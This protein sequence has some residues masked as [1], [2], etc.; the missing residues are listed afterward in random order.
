MVMQHVGRFR[1]ERGGGQMN[2]ENRVIA[3]LTQGELTQGELTQGE[4]TQTYAFPCVFNG[5]SG[6]QVEL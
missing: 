1:A 3:E 5:F 6:F 2:M 4:L